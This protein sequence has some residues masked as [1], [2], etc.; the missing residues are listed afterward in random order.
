MTLW[1]REGSGSDTNATGNPDYLGLLYFNSDDTLTVARNAEGNY[2]NVSV[3]NRKF[4]ISNAYY[5]IVASIDSTQATGTDRVKCWVNGEQQTLTFSTTPTQNRNFDFNQSGED[6]IIGQNGNGSGYGEYILSHVHFTD[7]T[8]YDADTFGETDST[9]GQWKIKTN[10]SVTYGTNGFFLFKNDNSVNDQSGNSNW[11]ASGGTLTQ[12]ED[13]PSN[14]FATW[15]NLMSNTP[16]D[17]AFSY[18]N[19]KVSPQTNGSYNHGISTLGMKKG[20]G[21]YYCEIKW[22]VNDNVGSAGIIESDIANHAWNDNININDHTVQTTW[23][24]CVFKR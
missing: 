8:T 4:R 3:A 16:S 6:H 5:H 9:T 22:H 20:D 18:G 24:R 12:T 14:V 7:G 2:I 10:P 21:K 17:H 13:N 1:K 11:T 15:N 23:G 19:T